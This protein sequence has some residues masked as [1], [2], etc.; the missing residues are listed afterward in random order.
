MI[1]C[2]V[3]GITLIHSCDE[4]KSD[5]ATCAIFIQINTE[6]EGIEERASSLT[7]TFSS[8]FLDGKWYES[9]LQNAFYKIDKIPQCC[10]QKQIRERKKLN[11]ERSNLSKWWHHGGSAV[12]VGGKP[13]VRVA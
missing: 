4:L 6:F 1:N 3:Y 2:G 9:D 10:F 5:S 11:Y 7:P 12:S 8:L 13:D